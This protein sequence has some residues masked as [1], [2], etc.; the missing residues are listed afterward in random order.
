MKKIKGKERQREPL[1]LIVKVLHLLVYF[2]PNEH[3]C[4]FVFHHT[5][6]SKLKNQSSPPKIFSW[7][8]HCADAIL[9]SSKYHQCVEI[10][11]LFKHFKRP[12]VSKN[13][14]TCYFVRFLWQIFTSRYYQ[15]MAC[16]FSPEKV[17]NWSY[18]YIENRGSI[19][20]KG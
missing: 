15:N 2:Y 6:F 3:D 10:R 16:I 17:L 20:S 5:F 18:F 13:T 19:R 1:R 14:Q 12:L 4:F 9:Y 11:A 8:R 7:I